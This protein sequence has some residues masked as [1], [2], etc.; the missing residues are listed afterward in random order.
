MWIAIGI[1]VWG[2]HLIRRA[3]G[4]R[5]E[6]VTTETIRPGGSLVVSSV[7]RGRRRR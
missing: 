3:V 4:R 5:P 2:S 1:V 6:V 7:E